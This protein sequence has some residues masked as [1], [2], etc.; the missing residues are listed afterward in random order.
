MATYF[1]DLRAVPRDAHCT[2]AARLVRQ[3]FALAIAYNLI[4]VPTAVLGHVTPLMAA[5]ATSLSSV[6]VVANV[7]RLDNGRHKPARNDDPVGH[8]AGVTP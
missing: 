5:V 3:N 2:A 4:A 7:L 1:F 6:T 8:T